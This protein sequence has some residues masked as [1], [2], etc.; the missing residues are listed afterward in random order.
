MAKQEKLSAE[1]FE[2]DWDRQKSEEEEKLEDSISYLA[3]FFD[4]DGF[5]DVERTESGYIIILDN[6]WGRLCKGCYDFTGNLV[7][8]ADYYDAFPDNYIHYIP[9]DDDDSDY[10]DGDSFEREGNHYY[11]DQEFAILKKIRNN[12]IPE[13]IKELS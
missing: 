6:G 7:S 5:V 8:Y 9:D 2:V 12:K 1:D 11:I 13:I 3:E 4:E 10:I